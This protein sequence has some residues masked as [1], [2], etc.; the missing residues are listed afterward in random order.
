[1]VCAD[2]RQVY[3]GME[4]GTA[5]PTA[6]ERARV[7]HHLIDLVDPD[8]AYS[9]GRY[10]RD[11]AAC[12]EALRAR[13]ARALVVGGTGL[14]VRA[15][16]WGL[17]DG[18][19][20]DPAL[21]ESWLRREQ[22]ELGVVYRRLSEVDPASAAAIHP[23]DLAKA[24]RAVEV[25]ELTG[26]PLSSRQRDHGFLA[27]QVDAVVIGLRR[28]RADLYGRIDSRVDAMTAQGLVAEVEGLTRRGYGDDAPGM[29]A[30]GYRQLAGA[31]KGAY[32]LDEAIRL[33]K[34]DSRRY[35]KRQMTWFGADSST[36]WVD[37]SSDTPVEE[38][39]DR[40]TTCLEGVVCGGENRRG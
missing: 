6:A 28:E 25:F 17:C 8:E 3:R 38:L 36:H 5:K 24:L 26:T 40:V 14:Y 29:R 12:L 32:G 10:A 19:T 22:N 27:P 31:L 7:P 37:A 18:P 35:A 30:V 39:V 13:G 21:R 33:V 4:I 2:S 34:R 23:N 1:I 9:A 11:A 20:A 15:L 16:L